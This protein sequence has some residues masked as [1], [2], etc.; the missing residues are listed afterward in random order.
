MWETIVH[1]YFI[2]WVALVLNA[3]AIYL[4]GKKRKVGFS[5][6]V[7]AN[8]AWIVF[9]ILAHSMATVVA[10]SIFVVLNMKGWWTWT[11]EQISVKADV[12]D[13]TRIHGQ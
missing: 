11:R 1:Y 10:C 8:I 13:D 5:L 12:G 4:L 6:G 2:D 3:T 7:A 9:G